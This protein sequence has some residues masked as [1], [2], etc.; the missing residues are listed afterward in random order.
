[1]LEDEAVFGVDVKDSVLFVPVATLVAVALPTISVLVN[2]D[3]GADDDNG[4]LVEDEVATFLDEVYD[5]S[6]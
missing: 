3:C 1:M 5:S 6:E 2:I 4:M